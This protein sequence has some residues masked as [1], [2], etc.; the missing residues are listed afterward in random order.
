M[1][2][3]I[4]IT[5]GC[6]FLGSNLCYHGLNNGY[7]IHLIDNLKREGS[8]DN[9]SWLKNTGLKNCHLIDICSQK[10]VE[11]IIKLVIVIEKR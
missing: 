8:K 4:L 5:G 6:G 7:E 9:L 10:E 2:K 11:N 3:K 1:R